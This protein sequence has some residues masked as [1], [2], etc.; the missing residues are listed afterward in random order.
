MVF[1][2]L[3]SAVHRL[4]GSQSRTKLIRPCF[5][6]EE[7]TAVLWGCAIYNLMLFSGLEGGEGYGHFVNE[8]NR[9]MGHPP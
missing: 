7:A 9:L 6:G 2:T 4:K 1:T 3:T 5:A 8:Q